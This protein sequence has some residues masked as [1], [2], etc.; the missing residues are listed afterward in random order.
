MKIN[1]TKIKI[2][3]KTS[4]NIFKEKAKSVIKN[5]KKKRAKKKLNKWLSK[6]GE[7]STYIGMPGS[8]KTTF[9]AY[10]VSLCLKAN[11]KVYSNVPILGAFPFT[12]DEFGK[13][14]MSEAV[15]IIDEGSLFYDNR[16]FDKNFNDN[17]L[18]YLKLLR[19][20]HNNILIFSQSIDV[21][22]KFVR[23]STSIFYLSRGIFNFTNVCHVRRVVD[24]NKDTHKFE[25]FYYKP[26]GLVKFITSKHIFRP[27]Y[28]KYFDSYDAPKLPNF[29]SS[30]KPYSSKQGLGQTL[31]KLNIPRDK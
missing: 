24:V 27:L 19:H 10:I 29:P 14:D 23:M 8:G 7:C 25:D 12:K 3:L 18:S 2:I 6:N 11:V 31:V 26:S 20:R 16:N 21:D 30:R 1:T 13:Y 9:C 22:V 5:I 15:I 28:Y 4:Y 17:S